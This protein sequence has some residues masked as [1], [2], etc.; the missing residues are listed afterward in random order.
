MYFII[1]NKN[2]NKA[3]TKSYDKVTKDMDKNYDMIFGKKSSKMLSDVF[4]LAIMLSTGNDRL[5][6]YRN[7]NF[8]GVTSEDD[9]GITIEK[10]GR[11]I[12]KNG[13]SPMFKIYLQCN[14]KVTT[15]YI[16]EVRQSDE[17]IVGL[18]A[19]AFEDF[20]VQNE[21][22]HNVIRNLLRRPWTNPEKIS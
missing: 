2:I 12:I 15:M 6:T 9:L 16:K 3:L 10:L 18:L 8:R 1:S 11:K 5:S 21:T 4:N 14:P 17:M 13:I 22:L 20:M 19:L 7:K